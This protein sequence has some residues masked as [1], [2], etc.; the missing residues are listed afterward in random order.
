MN[1]CRLCNKAIW[2]EYTDRILFCENCRKAVEEEI[3]YKKELCSENEIELMELN[4]KVKYLSNLVEFKWAEIM[5]LMRKNLQLNKENR[6]L[7]EFIRWQ[8]YKLTMLDKYR[9]A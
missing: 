6:H 4:D 2:K 3:W 8:W 1:R 7:K 9:R 5:K